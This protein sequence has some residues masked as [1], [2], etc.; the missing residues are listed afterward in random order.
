[1][2][3]SRFQVGNY[4]SFFE[5]A[6]LDFTPGFNIISGQNNA[7]KTALLEALG[8]D[9]GCNPHRSLRTIPVRGIAPEQLS[10][11]DIS[12]TMT[13]EEI[14][15]LMLSALGSR[16]LIL[17]PE[18]NST[19]AREIGFTDDSTE[20]AQRLVSAI[21]SRDNL[22]FT[23]RFQVG[24]GGTLQPTPPLIPSFG[25]YR[26]QGQVNGWR[27]A[28][29]RP[30]GKGQFEVVGQEERVSADFGFQLAS[31]FLRQHVYRFSAERLNIGRSGHGVET[32]LARNASNLPE[33]LS[34][35]QH[36]P[37][38]FQDLNDQLKAIL[39]QVKQVS[40]RASNPG[41]AEIVVWCHDPE[42]RRE[43]LV[44]PLSASGTGIG[45]V[46][47]VLYVVLTSDRPQTIIIDEP[48]SFLHP[49]A[50]RKLIEFLKLHPQHQ[51]II[52]THSATIISAA[53]PRTITL[54]TFEDGESTL[55]QLNVD[56]E[57]GIQRTLTELGIR[58]SDLFGADRILW[59]EGRTEEKC[60]PIIVQKLM[61]MPLM[62]VEILGIR[63]T[64]DLEGR[65]AKRVFGIYSSLAKG[66][67][68][69]PPALAFIFDDEDRTETTKNDLIRA[70]KNL[71]HFL[72][73]RMYENYLL[74]PEAIAATASAIEHFRPDP[75]TAG[76][77]LAAIEKKLAVR[78]YYSSPEKMKTPDDRLRN[79]DA[80]RVLSEIFSEFS[81]TRVAYQKVMHGVMLTE[82][83]IKNAPADLREIVEML[84]G[85][86]KT[87]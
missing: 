60:F 9:F 12:F 65:D 26:P 77:V 30:K 36:N 34:Q 83:L 80:A 82:R 4:K 27:A 45:Q 40:V 13:P 25:S 79:V 1:M 62:G 64:G 8:L 58:L 3:I 6:P 24:A 28:V 68:L 57:Q 78:E 71:A 11:A 51:F 72:P 85:V 43:D 37:N 22:T 20:S 33:V 44:V 35:L 70:S 74:N 29:F 17:K 53:N 38:R 69:I 61:Q 21:L 5:P 73:K 81:E 50:A 52:A 86:L 16:Y 2:Y 49:G 67:S 66:A 10:R 41:Q 31:D 76:E 63:E 42:S 56:V 7:G 23:I 32:Q 75:L 47:A 15:T 59:V 84:S 18:V 48:Q 55:Q 54:V 19:F 39:P 46:L 14:G 87:E